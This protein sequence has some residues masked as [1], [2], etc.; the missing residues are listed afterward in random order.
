MR[1]PRV[2]VSH[3]IRSLLFAVSRLLVLVLALVVVLPPAASMMPGEHDFEIRSGERV[4]RFRNNSL[5]HRLFQVR[6]RNPTLRAF[7]S[8]TTRV[9][10]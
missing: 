2:L 7:D 4:L 5:L 3:R 1:P 8:P 6:P 9:L 10:S